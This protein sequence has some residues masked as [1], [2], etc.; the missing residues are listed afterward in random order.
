MSRPIFTIG[1][2]TRALAELAELLQAHSITR[3]LDVRTIPRS[4]HNPQFNRETLPDSLEP[5]GIAYEHVPGLG[6][7]RHARA[8]SSNTG[9]E[10]ASFRGYADYMLSPEFAVN[11]QKLIEKSQAETVAIMCAEAVPWRCHRRMIADALL[12]QGLQVFHIYDTARVEAH[13]L[14]PWAKLKGT[15]VAYPGPEVSGTS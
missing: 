14:T 3:L 5:Y 8:D 12:A 1:H 2:S 10:N 7:L 11:L 15:V 6:G 4:R 9:W 13:V